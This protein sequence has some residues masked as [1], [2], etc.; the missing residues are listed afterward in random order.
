MLFR[1]DKWT[2]G[3]KL[4]DGKWTGIVVFREKGETERSK[5]FLTIPKERQR[6]RWEFHPAQEQ[7]PAFWRRIHVRRRRRL[8]VP[9]PS[10]HEFLGTERFTTK[11]GHE[12]VMDNWNEQGA[13]RKGPAW[14]GFT[15]FYITGKA[16]DEHPRSGVDIPP[17]MLHH[18]TTASSVHRTPDR[19]SPFPEA[20]KAVVTPE[21]DECVL[22]GPGRRVPAYLLKALRRHGEVQITRK[23]G[24]WHAKAS[25]TTP[26]ETGDL[27]EDPLFQSTLL[28]PDILPALSEARK[29][30]RM[31]RYGGAKRDV[32]EILSDALN[33]S[34]VKLSPKG[35]SQTRVLI[36]RALIDRPIHETWRHWGQWEID[37]ARGR[38]NLIATSTVAGSTPVSEPGKGKFLVS[39]RLEFPSSFKEPESKAGDR[40]STRLNSSHSSVSRMPSSA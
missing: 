28:I 40:K 26:A 24:L 8:Y 17:V 13:G 21:G 11:A 2:S 9:E 39:A 22:S 19:Q 33:P 38:T 20:A 29:Q 5:A 35:N 27:A 10:M 18:T 14:F 6:D 25:E 30:G 3:A 16:S 12:P 7:H 37:E 4:L 1:S 15:D 36:T 23:N 32:C 34:E 31:L